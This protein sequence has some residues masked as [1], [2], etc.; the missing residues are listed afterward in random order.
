MNVWKK[1]R[2][3]CSLSIIIVLFCACGL[4]EESTKLTEEQNA[5]VEIICQN[6]DKWSD[7]YQDSGQN[8]PVNHVYLS[9]LDD[10]TTLMTVG[11]LGESKGSGMA[12]RI[13]LG[14]R[15]YAITDKLYFYA[16]GY[17][18]LEWGAYGVDIDLERMSVDEIQ[19]V[20]EQS[21]LLFCEKNSKN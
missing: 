15:T 6:V 14:V 5:R 9:E 10:G 20:I 8:W 3:T 1:L 2:T 13:F 4:Q 19:G 12:T 16:A 21:Y 11:Y 7:E 17:Q 18:S